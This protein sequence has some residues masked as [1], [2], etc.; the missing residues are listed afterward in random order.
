MLINRIMLS[1]IFMLT[2]CQP[3]TVISGCWDKVPVNLKR[4]RKKRDSRNSALDS[5]SFSSGSGRGWAAEKLWAHGRSSGPLWNPLVGTSSGHTG[6]V[7]RLLSPFL[8]GS[9]RHSYFEFVHNI[10]N[11]HLLYDTYIYLAEYSKY[12]SPCR[13]HLLPLSVCS[14]ERS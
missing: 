10:K 3:H 14:A 1:K 11:I 13:I 4:D 8:S 6:T 7:G 9:A 5:H 2:T 12:N